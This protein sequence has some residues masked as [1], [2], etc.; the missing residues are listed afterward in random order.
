MKTPYLYFGKKG[1]QATAGVV[2]GGYAALT[3]ANSGMMPA[4]KNNA[5]LPNSLRVLFKSTTV[6]SSVRGGLLLTAGA[7]G[8]T[9]FVD[10]STLLA[11]TAAG[12][13]TNMSAL[14]KSFTVG[15]GDEVVTVLDV[16]D[17]S[18]MTVIT[19][20]TVYFEEMNFD[21][22]VPPINTGADNTVGF[23][24]LCMPATSYLGAEPLAFTEGVGANQGL[25]HDGTALDA[26]RLHFKSADGAGIVSSD[27]V[28]LVHTADKF[29]EVC[30][31]M[32]DLCNSTVYDEMIK[33]HYLTAADPQVDGQVVHNAFSSRGIL[34][35]R[36]LIT[37]TARS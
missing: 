15:S 28:D 34:I 35:K 17:T 23:A 36:C 7:A 21:A 24:D 19:G 1:Y 30:E 32:E 4:A 14:V 9:D 5:T 11:A 2:D 29:K 37:C 25:Y 10:G 27:T 13:V 22:T 8:L 16:S 33:V 12:E 3:I 20:D 26:T 31:A 6:V 18:G